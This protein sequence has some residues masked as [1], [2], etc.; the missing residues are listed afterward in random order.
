[1]VERVV[2][3]EETDRTGSTF[4]RL[5]K[6]IR[7]MGIGGNCP[8]I[9]IEDYAE[10]Y[11]K[12]LAGS[13]P[14]ECHVAVLVGELCKSEGKRYV[15]IRGALETEGVAEGREL[16]FSSEIWANVYERIKRFFPQYE[17]VGWFLGGPEYM[18]AIN[19]EI[20]RIHL[21]WFGGRDRVLYRVDPNEKTAS[22]YLY[23]NDELRRWPGYC[24][25]FDKNEEMR[26]YMIAKKPCSVD[27]N[28]RDPV[29]EEIRRRVGGSSERREESET[30]ETE[31]PF[32][33]LPEDNSLDGKTD[34]TEKDKKKEDQDTAE[35]GKIVVTEAGP[36]VQ[37]R[38]AKFHSGFVTVA[39]LLVAGALVYRNRNSLFSE[40]TPVNLPEVGT[41]TDA[42]EVIG[43]VKNG[44][45]ALPLTTT[46]TKI[47][48][49]GETET[50]GGGSPE[51]FTPIDEPVFLPGTDYEG[52]SDHTTETNKDAETDT[53]GK[54]IKE[55]AE[56]SPTKKP[57][58]TPE[59][60]GEAVVIPMELYIVKEGDTLAR[61]CRWYY[62]DVSRME[63]VKNL[64]Q[65]QNE[66]YI[67][68]GQEIYLP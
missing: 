9:Y 43:A 6:H 65:I 17:A 27:A 45:D 14:S 8:E 49:N 53:D 32:S 11:L 5:P 13:D 10:G 34:G 18:T 68:V 47:P 30:G 29:M 54:E 66:D 52:I 1:M 4:L 44:T 28:Y 37:K 58:E 59:Q 41:P 3:R 23:E 38:N 46:P 57:T 33:A 67:I 55:T 50:S 7:Q 12:R 48:E 2:Q 24:I 26:E 20:T 42:A 19:T 40:K 39:V 21:D 36:D 35:F 31:P 22:F 16:H 62:G 64:N 63:E 25:Y 61:I 56:L 51:G 15:F 60:S